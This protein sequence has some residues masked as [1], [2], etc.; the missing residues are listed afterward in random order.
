MPHGEG[1]AGQ[2]APA[3][4]S[5]P[6]KAWFRHATIASIRHA[7]NSPENLVKAPG[8]EPPATFVQSVANGRE[9]DADRA[10]QDDSKR[11]A[12]SAWTQMSVDFVQN[13]QRLQWAGRDS[14]PGPTD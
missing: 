11:R 6:A 13:I 14:N 3:H 7:L 2:D 12:V 8:N 5:P 4:W 9:N 10:R 1:R